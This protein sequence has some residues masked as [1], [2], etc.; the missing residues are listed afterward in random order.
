M[1]SVLCGRYVTAVSL[2]VLCT[3]CALASG[4]WGLFICV[5][6]RALCASLL[7][8]PDPFTFS[9]QQSVGTAAHV[10]KCCGC[11]VSLVLQEAL[12]AMGWLCCCSDWGL[13]GAG[14]GIVMEICLASAL[15]WVVWFFL[16]P[17]SHS[18]C[19]LCASETESRAW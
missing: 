12:A 18:H 3:L 4:D 19:Q 17:A 2:P 9:G 5:C 10:R 1:P 15:K 11:A 6:R 8:A 16:A 7:K 14:R 13:L